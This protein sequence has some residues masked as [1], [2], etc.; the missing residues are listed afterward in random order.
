[1]L[2]RHK[3][4]PAAPSWLIIDAR[5]RRR[6]PFAGAPPL[7]TPRGW[8]K[9]GF[10]RRASTIADLAAQCELDPAR[11][12]ATIDR[13][14]AMAAVGRD[15]DFGRGE[16][17]YD[18]FFSDPT[19][20]PNPNLGA[21]A[22]APFYAVRLYVADV[23][24]VGGLVT[25]EHARVVRE[26]GSVID[27]LYASGTGTASVTGRIYPAPGASIANAMIFGF[28]AADHVRTRERALSTP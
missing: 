2:E 8:L 7:V 24:T 1:M 21:I 10:M 15:E 14:N 3:T 5:H 19:N 18:R 26:D 28:I 13:F 23:A 22:K 9:S 12:Q 16:S 4:V 6:Y 25:D 20:R 27:G 11:L 17:S